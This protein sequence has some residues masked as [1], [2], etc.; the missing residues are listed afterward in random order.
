MPMLEN[1][2]LIALDGC[3]FTFSLSDRTE[4]NIKKNVSQVHLAKKVILEKYTLAP[5]S[6]Y[7]VFAYDFYSVSPIPP[8]SF[9][10]PYFSNPYTLFFSVGFMLDFMF[11]TIIYTTCSLYNFVPGYF[12]YCSI[13]QVVIT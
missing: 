8:T 12:K 5:L 2:N 1:I 7:K 4:Q 11:I 3:N 9:P 13:F 6:I 10:L